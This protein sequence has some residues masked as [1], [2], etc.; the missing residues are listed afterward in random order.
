LPNRV[1]VIGAGIGGLSAAA[2][3]A[4]D[5]WE[6]EVVEKNGQPGGRAMVWEHS[7]YKFDLGPSWYLMPDVFEAFFDRFCCKPSDFYAL[8]RLDPSYKIFFGPGDVV[9]IPAG[10]QPNI[11]LF[12]K[13]EPGA[14]RKLRDYVEVA[15]YQYR[16][17]CEEFLY[18]DYRSVLDFLN[19]RTL[20]EGRKL[21]VLESMDQYCRRFFHSDR[22]RKILQYSM[23]FLGGSPS[24]TPAL[25]S[26]LAHVDFNLGVWYPDGGIGSVVR[27]LTK[28]ARAQGVSF[29]FNE[30]IEGLIT[31]DGVVRGVVGPSGSRDA[32]I[33]VVNADYAHSEMNLLKGRDRSYP[34]GYWA[35]RV[36]APSAVMLYL[37]LN[38]KVE[39]LSHH[40]LSFANDWVGHF[41]S[42]FSNPGWPEKPSYYFCCPTQ[43]DTSIA[44]EA[45]DS[46]VALVPVAAGLDDDDDVRSRSSDMILDHLSLMIGEQIRPAVKVHRVWSQRDYANAFRAYKGT[47]LGLSHTLTQSAVF[48]PKHRS[49]RVK[50]L[51][52]TGQYTHPGIGLPMALIS[53]TILADIVRG[54]A[55]V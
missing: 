48:R 15:S 54:E 52:Y 43:T 29:T 31:D 33:V 28:L 40:T 19:R 45:C 53:S 16:A 25:Y 42:I 4:K 47:A 7:G 6:V 26:L 55:G 1:V 10:L 37:G 30:E 5:G 3:L 17:A 46:I 38:R 35:S 13:H 27:A 44:P 34:E 36:L 2:L 39:G 23:V 32:D 21:H 9:D 51:Y 24:N 18:K 8:R 49:R 14:G 11:D 41:E 50:R 20:I 12:E 22:L